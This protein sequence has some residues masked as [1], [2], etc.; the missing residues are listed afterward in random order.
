MVFF[1]SSFYYSFVLGSLRGPK[2]DFEKLLRLQ[3]SSS[4]IY[5]VEKQLSIQVEE[6]EIIR[7]EKELTATTRLPADARAYETKVLAEGSRLAK[8]K[9]AEGEAQKIR[10]LGAAD[11]SAIEAVS[12]IVFPK[13]GR[14]YFG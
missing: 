3:L 10:L 2:E 12:S 14:V 4:T 5:L 9:A 1:I 11:A 6:K 8:L 13:S 7:A